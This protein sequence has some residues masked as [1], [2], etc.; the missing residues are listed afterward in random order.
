[1]FQDRVD[2]GR[3]LGAMLRDRVAGPVVV[4]ALPRGGVPVGA[5]VARALDAPLDVVLVRKLGVPVQPEL[6]FGAIGEDGVRV[7]DQQLLRR[8]R[9]T[10]VQ[11]AQV[12]QRERAELLRRV[13]RYRALRPQEPVVG[14]AV[15]I[16]DDG[17]ATGS[18]ARAACQVARAHG[19]RAIMLAVP[20]AAADAVVA[21]REVADEVM[22]LEVPTR[23]GSVG[24]W[25][26]DFG[27]TTD[28]EVDALLVR[29]DLASSP[30]GEQSRGH[31]TGAS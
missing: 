8:T 27:Q 22:A 3:R 23:F 16:V 17:V 4:L 1:M 2:A 30:G 29:A 19:A 12:E 18:T 25:Y 14:R 21:L 13:E 28:R 6:A 7:V 26:V 10:D 20:V 24:Q 9:V 31:R 5:E 15:V 11:A